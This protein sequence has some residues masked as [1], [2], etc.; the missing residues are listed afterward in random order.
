MNAL[1]WK[2]R[3]AKC[4]SPKAA[5][6]RKV[7]L[8]YHAVGPR[9][10]ALDAALFQAQMEWLSQ[11]CD[12]LPLSELLTTH[13]HSNRVQV[14][15]TF[16]DG[17]A[18]VFQVAAPIL[19]QLKIPATVYLNTGWIADHENERRASCAALGHYPEEMF[20]IWDEVKT[21]VN[22]GWEMGSH[23]VNHLK[24]V[25]LPESQL[26][27]ELTVSKQTIET[28]LNR[29]CPQFAYTWGL[30][31]KPLMKKLEQ[32]QYRYG[33]AAHHAPLSP[34]DNRWALPRLNIAREYSLQD[35]KDIVSGRWDFLGWIQK[36]KKIR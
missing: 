5:S 6:G 13:P 36:I 28:R 33:I 16:D 35:F 12:V 15:I 19:D 14:A 4:F 29:P 31:S 30:H 8:L 20:L 26:M 10:W 7:I 2:R 9:G 24:F 27:E 25:E 22:R 32:A 1:L 34:R 3:L 21:L 17:Y 18:S 11:H 23:G